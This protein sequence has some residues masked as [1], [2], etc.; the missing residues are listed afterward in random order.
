MKYYLKL[1][2]GNISFFFNQRMLKMWGKVDQS[3]NII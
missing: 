3:K 1:Y 2:H